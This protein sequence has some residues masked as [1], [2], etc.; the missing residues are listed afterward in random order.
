MAE[1][2]YLKLKIEFKNLEKKVYPYFLGALI[3]G[4]FGYYLRKTVCPFNIRRRCNKCIIK[5][6]C[7]YY[8]VFETIKEREN[9]GENAPHPFILEVP[10]NEDEYLDTL[11]FSVIL[12]GDAL[13]NYEYFIL[14]FYEMAKGGLSRS[15]I[16]ARRV[17]IR[18]EFDNLIFDSK[19]GKLL[20]KPRYKTFSLKDNDF[21]AKKLEIHY[22][23][24]LRLF[25]EKKPVENPNFETLI[26]ALLRRYMYLTNDYGNPI[27]LD[28]K[29]IIESSKGIETVSSNV[30]WIKLKR[31]SSRKRRKL[32][33]GGLIGSQSFS[34][35]FS[36]YHLALL[37]FAEIF[38]IGKQVSFGHG[39]IKLKG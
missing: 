1:L 4:N 13:K 27:E 21:K 33:V 19:D 6:K 20:R 9:M 23:T 2:K 35:E 16:K 8:N 36:F 17:L 5:E 3:R 11:N 31:Y 34:G 38:H 10:F 26:R 24:P 15:K 39:Q 7:F 28:T 18:D 14:V 29:K 32:F 25:S 37:K 12:L 22:I 30:K